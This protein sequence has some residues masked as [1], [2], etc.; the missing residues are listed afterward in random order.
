MTR[1]KKLLI[2]LVILIVVVLG[3]IVVEWVRLTR[4][5]PESYAAWTTGNVI[6]DHLA[7]N[8]N[9]WPRSWDELTE[10]TNRIIW[11]EPLE[12]MRSLV[13]IDWN[14]DVA[15]LAERARRDPDSNPPIVTRPD[16]KPLKTRWGPETEPNG[17]IMDYLRHTTNPI[18]H[19]DLARPK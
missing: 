3:S 11:Y 12:R 19:G 18:P 1:V 6:V 14:V 7:R 2:V 13:R 4:A 10:S 8:T 15:T 17:K 16:G 9:R 5:L